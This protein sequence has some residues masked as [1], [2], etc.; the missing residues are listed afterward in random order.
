MRSALPFMRHADRETVSRAHSSGENHVGHADVPPA[1]LLNTLAALG[2]AQR[3]EL[4]ATLRRVADNLAE[5]PDGK[6][7][8][9]GVSNEPRIE[10]TR[11]W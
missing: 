11:L 9:F 1:D 6:T 7:A 3:P 2:P 10:T 5:V 8:E 4:A